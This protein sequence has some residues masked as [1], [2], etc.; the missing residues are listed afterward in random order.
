MPATP[1]E[2]TVPMPVGECVSIRGFYT[3]PLDRPVA[4]TRNGRAAPTPEQ[5]RAAR[6]AFLPLLLSDSSRTKNCILPIS[7]NRTRSRRTIRALRARSFSQLRIA[8]RPTRH[9]T[10]A[11]LARARAL[12]CKDAAALPKG[13]EPFVGDLLDPVRAGRVLRASGRARRHSYNATAEAR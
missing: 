10:F 9:S 13:V 1:R 2:N 4:R 11:H 12:I 3:A 6:G 8:R 7:P 5:R